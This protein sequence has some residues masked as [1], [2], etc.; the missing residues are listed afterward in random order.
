[1]LTCPPEIDLSCDGLLLCGGGDIHPSY[2]GQ[3]INGSRG[4]NE[5]RDAH[6]FAL[7]R[8]YVAAGKPIFGICRGHQLLNVLF[9]GTL[10]QHLPTA[11]Q[12][13]QR[14]GF[15]PTHP[16]R[17]I[18]ENFLSRLYGERLIVNTSHHQAVG[19]L[20]RDLIPLAT[21]EDSH[22]EAF[23]H[24]SLPVFGVQWHPEST[25][26]DELTVKLFAD[27]VNACK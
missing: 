12:H 13:M 20:G 25:P 21:W 26:K 4:I 11:E 5:A 9:G 27:F 22:I 7:A 15:F 23:A 8:A 17:V 6:E 14:N 3:E 16:V 10:V 2:Y 18:G 24:K 1:M 19:V